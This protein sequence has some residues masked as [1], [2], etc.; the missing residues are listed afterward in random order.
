MSLPILVFI[1]GPV[2]TEADCELFDKESA[3]QF[4]N[5]Q[6]DSVVII[7]H[8]KAVAVDPALIPDGYR[9]KIERVEEVPAAPANNPAAPVQSLPTGSLGIQAVGT[10]DKPPV[11]TGAPLAAFGKAK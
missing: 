9:T 2:P 4:V 3:D 7:P 8:A 5:A 1:D 11:A 10:S 6:I